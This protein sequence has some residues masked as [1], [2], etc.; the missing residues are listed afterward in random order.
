M[1][2]YSEAIAYL[3][4]IVDYEKMRLE[5][6]TPETHNL[7]RVERLLAAIEARPS[8]ISTAS[9][10]SMSTVIRRALECGTRMKRCLLRRLG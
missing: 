2:N 4:S 3:Y 8:A 9:A 10:V 7:S 6:Y 5:R 1:M